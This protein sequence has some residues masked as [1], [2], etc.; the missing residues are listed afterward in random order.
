MKKKGCPIGTIHDRHRDECVIPKQNL[1]PTLCWPGGKSRVA[2]EITA[3][4]PKH[5]IFVEPFVGGAV[6]ISRK[7]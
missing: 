7:H 1:K 5:N 6:Y 3:K 2:K 4:I